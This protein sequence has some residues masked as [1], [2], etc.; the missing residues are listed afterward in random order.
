MAV[1]NTKEKTRSETRCPNH[2]VQNKK[3]IEKVCI[4][5]NGKK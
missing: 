4:L 3:K 2:Y 1:M 5:E